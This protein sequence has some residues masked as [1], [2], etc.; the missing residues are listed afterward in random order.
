MTDIIKH[1]L[2]TLLAELG[3]PFSNVTVDATDET[4]IRVDIASPQASRLIGWHGETLDALQHL[5]KSIIRAKHGMEKAPFIVLDVDGYKKVQEEKV[6]RIAE[7][8]IDFVRR[9]K[10][11]VALP[12]MSPYFRR[13]VHLFISKHPD[14]RDIETESVGEGDYRQVVLRLKEGSMDDG[15]E[16]QPVIAEDGA[17]AGFENLDV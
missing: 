9:K 14:Y 1:T 16:L 11:R 13:I 15:E 5:V 10:T 6:C 8:K 3:L 4:I 7:Q 17:K 2:E 12:P